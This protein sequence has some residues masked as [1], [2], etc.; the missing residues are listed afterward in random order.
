MNERKNKYIKKIKKIQVEE[1]TY[2]TNM[3]ELVNKEKGRF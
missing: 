3:E 1:E 2:N